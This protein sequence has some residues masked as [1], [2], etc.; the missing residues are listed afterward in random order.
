LNNSFDSDFNKVSILRVLNSKGQLRYDELRNQSGFTTRRG[1]GIFA[2]QLRKLL[3][4]S[5]IAQGKSEKEYVITKLGKLVLHL[6][7]KKIER[8]KT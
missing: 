1:D 7:E 3:R 2:Y 4:E 5:L 6:D 8:P